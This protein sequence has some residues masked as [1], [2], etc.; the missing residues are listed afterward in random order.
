[1]PACSP[2]SLAEL[3]AL[4]AGIA[5]Q[6]KGPE[7]MPISCDLREFEYLAGR[8]PALRTRLLDTLLRSNQSDLALMRDFIDKGDRPAIAEV[9]HKIKGPRRSSRHIP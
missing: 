8:D 4:L 3:A 6:A 9:A 2:I 5:P 1:M 7:P